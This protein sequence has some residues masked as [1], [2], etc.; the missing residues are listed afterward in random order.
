LSQIK[1]STLSYTYPNSSQLALRDVALEIRPGAF[2]L[3]LGASGSGKST[4]L[5][6]L[7]GL[8]PHFSGGH[9]SGFI[10]VDGLD[11]VREGPSRMAQVV[12]MVF[13]DPE[14]QFV[15]DRVEDEVAFALEN[16]A[17]QPAE[18]HAR[19][20]EALELMEIEPLR[21]RPISSLSGGEQQR[22]AI[23]AAL[24]LRPRIL[25]LDEPTSQL[26]PEAADD[27]MNALTRLN[28]ERGLTIVLA[29][30]RVERVLPW[31]DQ[32]ILVQAGQVTAGAPRDVLAHTEL[33]PPVVALG[34]ALGWPA[35]PLSVEE[36]R[37]ATAGGHMRKSAPRASA[38]SSA[39]G[40][41][42]ITRW[43][44]PPALIL[45]AVRA[46]YQRQDVLHEVSLTVRPREMVALMGHNGAG[47]STLLK[48]IVGLVTPTGGDIQVN[49]VSVVGRGTWDICRDV[50]YLPQNPNA[51]LFADTVRDEL[52]A[53]LANHGMLGRKDVDALLR[54]L[55]LERYASAYPRDLSVGER[56]RVAVGAVTV[57]EP[58]LLLLDEP[59][60]GLDY[61]AKRALATL[62][63]GWKAEGASVLLVT[64]DVEFVAE[65]VDRVVLMSD[66]RVVADGTPAQVLGDSPVF[67]PQMAQVFPG[68]GW[69]TVEDVVTAT[70]GMQLVGVE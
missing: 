42:S 7:N 22:V 47:K 56:E 21:R 25:V 52:N 49:G 19:V 15:L 6:C 66:G 34:K 68:A 67:A 1:I 40:D 37:Q 70:G 17:V 45:S 62:L 13:Q 35:L 60:R 51:L 18:M 59:T 39:G 36:A 33:V 44:M 11:P 38:G 23:A 50:A 9:I 30:H 69:L 26:D 32:V 46:G 29:E 16:A 2:A 65:C 14:S 5:R 61:D 27:L 31:V 12:G 10:R 28:R 41:D 63:R 3:V 4:L 24:V 53:T 8:V 55:G 58:M 57:T 43:E 48:C 54:R 20:D 64:H